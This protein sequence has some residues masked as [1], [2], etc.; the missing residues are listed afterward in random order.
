MACSEAFKREK[1][2]GSFPLN[3]TLL[4]HQSDVYFWVDR[5][6][7]GGQTRSPVAYACHI[8]CHPSKPSLFNIFVSLVSTSTQTSPT[9]IGWHALL[10]YKPHPNN[11]NNNNNSQCVFRFRGVWG[12]PA[13]GNLTCTG[14]PTCRETDSKRPTKRV[15][16]KYFID[17]R[18]CENI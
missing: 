12:D 3:V 13:I 16:R 8:S 9:C 14:I 11:N 6:R 5:H 15:L 18:I 1:R 10:A 17:E 2:M 7:L 4:S